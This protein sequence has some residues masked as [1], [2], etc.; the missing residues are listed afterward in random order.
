MFEFI[1]SL[2]TKSIMLIVWAVF[3]VGT[4]IIEL[5][6]ADLVTI[7]FTLG[8]IGA[9][10]ATA[11]GAQIWL[12]LVIFVVIS[13]AAILGTRPIAKKL[14]QKEIIRTNADKVIGEIAI[15][16]KEISPNDFGEVKID[17]RLWRAASNTN[18]KFEVG[19]KVVVEAISG[20]KVI[21]T[22]TEKANN[23]TIL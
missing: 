10:I 8:G 23:E 20:A 9:L 18:L 7:W 22:K 14:Q 12:Q 6:T 1:L 3:V 17:G 15:V 19:E 2:D 5:A 4:A 13:V 11:L 16:T 21:V